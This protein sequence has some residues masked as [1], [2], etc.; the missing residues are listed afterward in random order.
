MRDF[1]F[2]L[3]MMRV[4]LP[5]NSVDRDRDVVGAIIREKPSYSARA[6]INMSHTTEI[7]WLGKSAP[8]S[9]GPILI[10]RSSRN[11]RISI[12]ICA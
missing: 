7:F 8:G 5:R 6:D 10:T 2:A 11:E 12:N 9:F 4:I 3:P 1:H